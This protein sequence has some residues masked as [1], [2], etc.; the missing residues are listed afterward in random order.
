MNFII[1]ILVMDF[2]SKHIW[3]EHSHCEDLY[4][5]NFTIFIFTGNMG[6]ALDNSRHDNKFVFQLRSSNYAASF[7]LPSLVTS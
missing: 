3:S 1:K 7:A 2:S 4:K 5:S 6:I